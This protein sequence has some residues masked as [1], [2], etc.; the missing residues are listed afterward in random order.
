MAAPRLAPALMCPLNSSRRGTEGFLEAFGEYL[1]SGP[2]PTPPTTYTVV[3]PA[4][5]LARLETKALLRFARRLVKW[6]I[7]GSNQ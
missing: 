7:L 6:A 5:R 4:A 2:P 1:R 3:E